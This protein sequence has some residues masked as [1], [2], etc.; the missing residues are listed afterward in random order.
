[1]SLQFVEPPAAQ[2]TLNILAYG[3]EGVG[4]TTGALSAPGPILYLNAEGPNAVRYA[5]RLY[6]DDKIHEV[7]VTGPA[8]LDA[9]YNHLKDSAEERTLV[10]DTIGAV[11]QVI[12]EAYAG[13]GKP[14]LPMYGDTT[15]KIERFCRALRDLPC[16][17]VVLAHEIAV[18][19][20]E[21]G[22]FERMPYTGT[23][24]PAL[25]VKIMAM[26]DV[27]AYCG[28]VDPAEGE[29]G[30]TRYMAQLIPAGGRRGKDRTGVL[31]HFPDLNITDWVQ[32]AASASTPAT[33]SEAR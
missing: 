25:G 28:R 14:T 23:N 9:V 15:T 31:G 17:V 30:E 24:S 29:N 21:S 3:R 27:V 33:A 10:V 16:N 32:L 4:K 8:T 13:D 11:F 7:E 5:R 12:L 19:D 22:Q 2:P 18:K 20:E 1:M 6:G 26:Y